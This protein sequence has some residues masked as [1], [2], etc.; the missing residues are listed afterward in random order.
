[1]SKYIKK[2]SPN[3]LRIVNEML[4]IVNGERKFEGF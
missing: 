1:M 3:S 4:R 2:K